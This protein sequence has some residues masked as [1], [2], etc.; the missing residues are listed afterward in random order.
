MVAAPGS[1]NALIDAYAAGPTALRHG[2][3]TGVRYM[4]GA[5]AARDGVRFNLH[6]R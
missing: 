3:L 5:I 4:A 6:L 2:D 1:P